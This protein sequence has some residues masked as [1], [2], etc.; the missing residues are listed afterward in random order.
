MA[1]STTA[2]SATSLGV[3]SGNREWNSSFGFCEPF[4]QTRPMCT[5]SVLCIGMS[6]E[7]SPQ[8]DL[9]TQSSACPYAANAAS[10]AA[11]AMSVL[12]I[13]FI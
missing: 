4:F 9:S 8:T 3:N 12:R 6:A 11:A 7:T 13:T 5:A 10:T 2:G 1:A